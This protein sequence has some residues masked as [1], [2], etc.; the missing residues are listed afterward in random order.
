[1]D[2]REDLIESFLSQHGWQSASRSVLAGDASNRRY[3]RLVDQI[4]G[5][6]L[7]LMDAPP[8]RGEDI[9]PFVKIAR[10]LSKIGLSAPVV[11]GFDEEAGLMLL[12]DLGD[13]LFS[14][15]VV[16]QPK[17]ETVLYE[18]AT[19][20]LLHL[21][22][23]PVQNDLLPYSPNVAADLS[24]L[25]Y[26]WYLPGMTGC[27][28]PDAR[29]QLTKVLTQLL[30]DVAP[31]TDV[32]IQRDYHSENLLWLP[33]RKDLKRVGLLDFQ[34]AMIGHR[35][36]DLVS[37]LQDA[38]RDVTPSLEEKILQRYIRLSAQEDTK[39]RL[40]Y[41][42]FAIQRNLRILGVFARLCVRD[43]KDR[44]VNFMPRVWALLLRN[45]DHPAASEV[46][47]LITNTLP[48]PTPDHIHL[49]VSKCATDQMQS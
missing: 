4:A 10:H 7:V 39:F 6:H 40:A 14:R 48:A 16:E 28:D 42:A 8:A 15:V 44:Y 1:M 25:I 19:D 12:E 3:W 11:F 2:D 45:L 13:S 21:H 38:R 18:A 36:Y 41:A 17:R 27:R 9:R 47:N 20:V 23:Q 43:G 46:K 32:L 5:K 26:D 33:D 29:D 31:Q 34:D 22:K 30:T 24:A 37:L 35:T 49:M